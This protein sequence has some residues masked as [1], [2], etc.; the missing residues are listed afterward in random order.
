M[1][2]ATSYQYI[3]DQGFKAI[4]IS[5][6][7]NSVNDADAPQYDKEI[8]KLGLPVLGKESSALAEGFIDI[9]LLFQASAMVF[10]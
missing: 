2:L 8:L 10:R 6:G 7:P 5:G 9:P 3:K 1:P 4:V